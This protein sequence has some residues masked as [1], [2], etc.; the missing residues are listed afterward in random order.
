M[1][2]MNMHMLKAAI[3]WGLANGLSS[4]NIRDI[5]YDIALEEG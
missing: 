2:E 5:A 3:R 4:N 1:V